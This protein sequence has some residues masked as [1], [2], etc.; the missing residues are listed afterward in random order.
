MNPQRERVT[1]AVSKRAVAAIVLPPALGLFV[2]CGWDGSSS[3]C[4]PPQAYDAGPPVVLFK[5]DVSPCFESPSPIRGSSPRLVARFPCPG[6]SSRFLVAVKVDG[7]LLTLHPVECAAYGSDVQI[8]AGPWEKS[9]DEPHTV[10]VIIDP[11]NLFE[12]T[13]ESN[14]RVTAQVAVVEPDLVLES[15]L[16][17]FT[18]ASGPQLGQ[19]V[20]EVNYGVPIHIR[21]IIQALGRYPGTTLT[22]QST[23]LD[24]TYVRDLDDCGGP[25]DEAHVTH[26]WLP[27]APGFYDVTFQVAA[28][29]GSPD[30]THNNVVIKRLRVFPP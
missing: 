9:L 30:S 12:E 2:G 16:C 22:L 15:N 20:T 6:T 4:E 28:A 14:N 25:W 19:Q 13:D 27:P 29:T 3:G 11:M 18:P 5:H 8:D 26:Y 17:W 7:E 21:A 1:P 10:E 23:G 24:T